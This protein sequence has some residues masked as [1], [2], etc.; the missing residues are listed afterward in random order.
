V[1]LEVIAVD[2]GSTDAGPAIVAAMAANDPRL[3]PI[4]S[5]GV[6]IV[7]ALAAGLARARGRFVA[8]MD[9]DD[10]S[11]PGRFAAQ[12][13]LLEQDARLGVVGTRVEA[14]PALAVGEGLRRYLAW[15]NALVS[16]ED[17]ERDLF[18]ESPLCHPS[19][20]LPRRVL[21]ELGGWR[22]VT[23]AEDYDLWLRISS[24]GYRIAKVP[25][26]LLRWRH[27]EGRMTF[28][29]PRF[30]IARFIEA[31]ACYLAPRLAS[32]GRPVAVWGA[33][34][35]GK[36]IARALERH[37]VRAALFVD[38][39]PRKVGGIARGA[40]VVAPS[41]VTP[42]V[43]TVVVAVGARGARERCRCQMDQMGFVEGSDYVCAA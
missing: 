30:T 38:I 42:G 33:G 23:W 9:S 8:R 19:V 43:H 35:T 10:V 41:S 4:A 2:D 34:P 32:T 20:M 39:D 5:G 27:R 29:D 6:G 21:V 15:Q 7:G 31:K 3:V 13:E 14:F 26:V 36:Q 1:A 37:G 17:H 28:T 12:I 40:P 22:E 16:P 25:R 18:V 11:L 24:A